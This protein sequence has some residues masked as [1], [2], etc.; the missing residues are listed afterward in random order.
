[1]LS[2]GRGDVSENGMQDRAT[3]RSQEL[4]GYIRA[5]TNRLLEVMGTVPLNPEELDDATLLA[6]DPI[7]IVTD[8]FEQVLEHLQKT[9]SELA[10]TR[11]ELQAIFDSRGRYCGG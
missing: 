9:N 10:A 2:A 1:M 6:V 3:D 4:I 11:D 7:G 8:S 5:K